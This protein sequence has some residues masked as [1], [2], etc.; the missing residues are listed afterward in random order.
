MTTTASPPRYE[1]GSGARLR[2]HRDRLGATT[3][4]MADLLGMARRSYQ[5][6]ERGVDAV[7]PGLWDT[8]R[9][10]E[11]AFGNDV[12]RALL[13]AEESGTMTIPWNTNDWNRRV[14]AEVLYTLGPDNVTLTYEGDPEPYI[15]EEK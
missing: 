2:A 9:G 7:P 5:R 14:A 4:D 1:W 13:A 3:M 6:M 15:E 11:A 12:Q 10:V 8:V